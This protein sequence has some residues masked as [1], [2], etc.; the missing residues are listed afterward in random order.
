MGPGRDARRAQ[1]AVG[2]RVQLVPNARLR[3]GYGGFWISYRHPRG[4]C[5]A[6]VAK[7]LSG[8]V[9]DSLLY[10]L[11]NLRLGNLA[12][13]QVGVNISSEDA[14]GLWWWSFG[15]LPFALILAHTAPPSH[16][17]CGPYGNLGG[18]GSAEILEPGFLALP[19]VSLHPPET[20]CVQPRPTDPGPGLI[21]AY[22]KC[23]PRAVALYVALFSWWVILQAFAWDFGRS[24]IE[25]DLSPIGAQLLSGCSGPPAG[26]PHGCALQVL[27]ERNLAG[28]L[29]P[30]NTTTP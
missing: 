13:A 22:R 6:E 17:L 11:H 8:G 27:W 10:R 21:W 14:S 26:A 28:V 23:D 29:L 25:L 18:D 5:G 19:T 16:R 7:P 3:Q 24:L 30:L 4:G 1:L 20:V 9:R 15:V 2:H 12:P